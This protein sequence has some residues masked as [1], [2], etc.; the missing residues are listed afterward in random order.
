[1]VKPG[2]YRATILNHAISETRGGN[3]Q[4]AVTFSFEA[5]GKSHNM[6]WFGSFKEGKAQE[7]TIKALLACGLK[8]NNPAG[9]LDIGKEVS[10]TVEHETG[11]DGKTRAKIRWVNA[12]GGVK[13]VMPQD[14]AK[15]KLDALQG[16]VLKARTDL[17]VPD[18]TDEIPF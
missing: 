7:I 11:D 13:N 9:E 6:T 2:I 15:S 17:G 5:D 1:M 18:T 16:A 8:G 12:L 10:I 4:A 14:L 3:P